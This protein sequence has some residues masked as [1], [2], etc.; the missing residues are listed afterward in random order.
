MFTPLA[1]RISILFLLA[2]TW[3]IGCA[4]FPIFT[5]RV[6]ERSAALRGTVSDEVAPSNARLFITKVDHTSTGKVYH[7][8][9]K[10]YLNGRPENT[11]LVF[12]YEEGSNKVVKVVEKADLKPVEADGHYVNIL[13]RTSYSKDKNKDKINDLLLTDKDGLPINILVEPIWNKDI[14]ALTFRYR[15]HED[16]IR[17]GKWEL[18]PQHVR[19]HPILAELNKFSYIVSVPAD[20]VVIVGGWSAFIV[21]VPFILVAQ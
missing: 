2:L 8:V 20:A 18:I 12:D 11:G 10:D 14:I 15:D 9:L 19:R 21:A 17:E 4:C 16:H 5:P 1:L 13:R 3:G 6:N 7:L